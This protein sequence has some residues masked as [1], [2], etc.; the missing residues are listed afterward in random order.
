M[1]KIAILLSLLL[2]FGGCSPQTQSGSAQES[3]AQSSQGE[4]SPDT[5]EP[6]T[7][8]TLDKLLAVTNARRL[9]VVK[10][11]PDT[12]K[13]ENWNTEESEPTFD[14]S[15]VEYSFEPSISDTE[16]YA[17]QQVQE[18][19]ECLFYFYEVGYGPYFYFGG[20]EAFDTAK[21]AVLSDLEAMTEI[22]ALNLQESLVKHLNFVQDAHFAFNYDTAVPHQQGYLSE[23][24]FL[25]DTLGFCETVGGKRVLSV[26]GKQN[27][28]DHMVLSLTQEGD[29]V[30]RYM[31]LST[32]DPGAVELAF[33]DGE[34][35]SASLFASSEAAG[36]KEKGE[37]IV[38]LDRVD[39][40]PVIT[41][42]QMGFPQAKDDWGANQFLDL[43]EQLRDE[44]VLIIDLRSNGG[45]NGLLPQMF[46]ERLTGSYITPNH[47]SLTRM[48]YGP[49]EPEPDPNSFY[50]IPTDIHKHY[51][52]PE[53]INNHWKLE[54]PEPRS[55]A[56][57]D[58]LLIVLTSKHTASSADN[59][60]DIT[61]NVKN[62]VVIGSNTAGVMLSTASIG[63]KA[64]NTGT[65]G[66]MGFNL[67][68]Y[69]PGHFQE[70]VGIMPDLWASGDALEAA[71]ILAKKQSS[72]G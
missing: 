49:N 48:V 69:D 14:M 9:A 28:A 70:G 47:Y 2:L 66:Q 24:T 20:K 3:A 45:G 33:E 16:V 27:F 65:I 64:P 40:V 50:Y 62:S 71:L 35:R 54:N 39:G 53:V 22:T 15:K 44:P 56:E 42:N 10:P 13:V 43:A 5:V 7:P 58:Q 8:D 6:L 18:D 34:T 26:A 1:N 32:E 60:T 72:V 12:S 11:T 55:M 25:Q 57:R 21:A 61:F 63:I 59:F 46:Y 30:Y 23:D 29:I 52:K 19:L 31:L 4:H 38:S 41:I 67:A 68:V 51:T 36:S 17:F 37:D